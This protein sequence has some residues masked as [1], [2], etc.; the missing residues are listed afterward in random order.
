MDQINIQFPDG[1]NKAFDKGTTTEDIAQSIS[2]GLRKKAVAGKFNNTLV[3]LTRPLE[4]DGDI[5]IV[6]PG[7]EEALEVLRH[8][9]AHLMAQALKR[10]YGDVKFG[11][12]PVID[13]GFYYDFDMEQSI[14]SDDFEQIE[15]TMKQIVNENFPIERKVVSRQEAQTFF[16][17]D[18]YKLELIDAIPEDE[19]VTLYSQGEF[20]DLCRGVHVPST[21][22][23]KEFK[24]LST[25]G[26]YW[27]GDSNNKMLQRIYG[28][29][30]FDKKDLK[31]HLQMLEERKER[32][33]RRIGKDLELFSNNPLV[34]AGL[35]LWLPN[36]ATIRREIER[37]I[38][39][40]EVSMGYDHVYTPVMANVDLYKTSG[41]WDHYQEDMFPTMKLDEQE[42]MVLRPMNCPHH[43]MIYANKPHSYRELPIRIAELGTMH[44]YESSGAVSGLQ[45]VRGMTLNDAHIFVRPDQIKEEFKRVVN[46]IMEVYEDFGFE[47]YNFRLSYRD[48]ADKEKYF[49]DD[50]MWNT[51]ENMLKEAVD[52]LG[53][54]YVE[55]I[56]EAAFYGPKLDVQVQ[57]AMG[58]EE[59]LSTA[60]LDFL[61]P[62]KFDL[63]YIGNDG[64]QHRPVVIHRGVVSTMERFVA[65][66]T[67]ETKGA[68]PTWL[69]PK[70]VEIIPVNVDLH[71][72]YAR[73]LQDELKSQ[74]VRVE[75]DDRNE[76]MGYK[77]R[78]AQMQKI[79]YQL[80]VGDKEVENNEVNVRK[81]GSQDQETIERDDF[82]WSL[83]DEIR[84][85][86]AR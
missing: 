24:L 6:T 45:R 51:A 77:I 22:K 61:L 13:G 12:G 3:D 53:L 16:A 41:H 71:Y 43:M 20:T 38:V 68:F 80:V 83:I 85:K 79:P 2:P 28:T 7:S 46:L 44:R 25:A 82:I 40:K 29:A 33:H 48:P 57:T 62:Q 72:D 67:E 60:Q 4:T 52:E 39:D 65:F 27:R 56:G 5:E 74:G 9:T 50:E 63:T 36:G 17:D 81:Y 8:S 49:D 32:D 66:L 30:F 1:N 42:E 23:I 11:V 21:A 10:L 70:Q 55:A 78:E 14:S 34:G 47:N 54:D 73:S 64:E 84:L 76:K 59:T 19:S 35:P 75:I 26:A 18:P 15:K 69:A 31:A 86:K 37:Y 58:K